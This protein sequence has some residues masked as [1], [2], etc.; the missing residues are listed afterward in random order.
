MDVVSVLK[1]GNI[2]DM[3]D[4]AVNLAG[5]LEDIIDKGDH[6]LIKPNLCCPKSN[7]S[8]ATTNPRVV[9]KLIDLVKN[10]DGIPLVGE[11]PIVGY[12]TE[13]VFYRTKYRLL[14]KG[15]GVD[16]IDFNADAPV[17]SSIKGALALNE[18]KIAKPALDCDKFI[19]VPVMKTHDACTVTLSLKNLKGCM[20]Q[21]EKYAS[22][23][24]G[25]HEAIVDLNKLIRPDF[26]VVDAIVG[27]EG[28]GPTAGDPVRMNMIIAGKDLASVDTIASTIMG[29]DADKIKH[30]KYAAQNGFGTTALQKIEVLG[31]PIQKV[32]RKFKEAT[33]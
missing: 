30:I 11:S 32:F 31:E 1:D 27:M 16:I 28:L 7:Q 4:R 12:D 9:L 15:K 33:W 8:G 5:G 2:E 29:F 10:A 3:V 6:V 21:N 23:R 17:I 19:S 14:M 13:E 22:H 25:V 24:V 26:A 18:V 20:Y